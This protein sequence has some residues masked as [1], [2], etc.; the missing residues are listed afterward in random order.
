[1]LS[2]PTT[3]DLNVEHLLINGD[4]WLTVDEVATWL[5]VTRSWLKTECDSGRIPHHKFGDRTVRFR[6]SDLEDYLRTAWRPRYA[7]DS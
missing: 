4:F 1:M 5:R 2:R 7:Y 6:Y 3:D